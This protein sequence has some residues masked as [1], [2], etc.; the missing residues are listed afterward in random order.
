MLAVISTRLP[1]QV[2]FAIYLCA[3]P[4]IFFLTEPHQHKHDN[5]EGVWKGIT[6]IV[7]Y[8]LHEHKEVKWLILFSGVFSASTLIMTWLSQ[9]YFT[10]VELPLVYFG[11]IWSV[12]VLSLVPAS[13]FAHRIEDALGKRRSLFLMTSL[14]IIG[15][16]LLSAVDVIYGIV[17]LFLFYLAR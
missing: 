17:I 3:I 7:R 5:K 1:L 9:Y 14:P 10:A 15:F 11:V 6:K 16:F 4:L 2:E 8:S 12:L 13:F